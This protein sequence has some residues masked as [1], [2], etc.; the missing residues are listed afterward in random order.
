MHDSSYPTEPETT[1][2]HSPPSSKSPDSA[3][4]ETLALA[5]LAWILEDSDR[6]ARY[7]E[8]T[9]LGPE[10][11]REGLGDRT[12]LASALDF[13][14]NYEPDLLRAAE[15]LDTQPESLIAARGDLAK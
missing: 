12:V 4:S 10:A 8:L 3:T 7:L 6:A 11:L 14:A 2:P 5:A 15:A 13:L 1:M 9:G